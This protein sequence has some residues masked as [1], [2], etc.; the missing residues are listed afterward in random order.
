MLNDKLLIITELVKYEGSEF[1]NDIYYL[2]DIVKKMELNKW[3]DINIE[4]CNYCHL[5]E[6]DEMFHYDDYDEYFENDCDEREFLNDKIFMVKGK[7]NC[8]MFLI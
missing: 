8:F 6:N 7:Q 2:D 4:D 5:E 3:N 1:L